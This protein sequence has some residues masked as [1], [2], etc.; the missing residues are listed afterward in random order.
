MAQRTMTD[1]ESFVHDIYE[2]MEAL[3]VPRVRT[4]LDTEQIQAVDAVM[5]TWKRGLGEI[6]AHLSTLEDNV[7]DESSVISD[8]DVREWG[9]VAVVTYSVE[10]WYTFAGVRHHEVSPSTMILRRIDGDWKLALFQSVP[11]DPH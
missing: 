3:D 4:M 1:I 6:G 8:M 2:A 10:Q 9:D 11:I 5:K 7:S